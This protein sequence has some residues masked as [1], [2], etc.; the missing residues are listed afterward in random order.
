MSH[1]CLS[2]SRALSE[3]R[4]KLFL[5][6]INVFDIAIDMSSIGH[7]KTF[8]FLLGIKVEWK[9]KFRS[10]NKRTQSLNRGY[11]KPLSRN[12][13]NYLGRKILNLRAKTD[14][15]TDI[16][17]RLLFVAN[18]AAVTYIRLRE[19]RRFLSTRTFPISLRNSKRLRQKA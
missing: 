8:G 16:L 18:R 10:K 11:V 2:L 17:R 5:V 3:R 19:S 15:K 4:R 12:I 9:T 1:C 7:Q 14:Y 6:I 13:D